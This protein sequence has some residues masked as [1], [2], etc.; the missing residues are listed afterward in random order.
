MPAAEFIY[1]NGTHNW[2]GAQGSAGIARAAAFLLRYL[3]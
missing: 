3:S 2:P 1:G